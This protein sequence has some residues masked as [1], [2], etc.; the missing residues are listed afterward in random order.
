VRACV[1]EAWI[2]V[3]DVTYDP[4]VEVFPALPVVI[5]LLWD[6]FAVTFLVLLDLTRV[7]VTV[8]VCT[9]LLLG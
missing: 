5:L 8:I 2:W 1:E 4:S 9:T 3:V 7:P 6:G